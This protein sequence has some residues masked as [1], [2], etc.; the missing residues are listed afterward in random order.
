MLLLSC[1]ILHHGRNLRLPYRE[2][3]V[4]LLPIKV[5]EVALL[6]DPERASA[7]DIA[8]QFADIHCF[9]E[10]DQKM[11][12]IGDTVHE[13]QFT[14]VVLNDAGNISKEFFIDLRS[15]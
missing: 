13:D 6:F 14:A 7:F 5:A 11:N 3:A 15:Y 12:M 10:R 9:A 2:S 8:D 1:N 4:I